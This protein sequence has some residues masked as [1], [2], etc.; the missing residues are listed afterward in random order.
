MRLNKIW[1]DNRESIKTATT[2][3]IL[4]KKRNRIDQ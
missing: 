3:V 1:E 2:K 4:K